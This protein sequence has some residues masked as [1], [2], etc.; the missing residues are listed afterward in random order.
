[1]N[2]C[3]SGQESITHESVH[4]HDSSFSYKICNDLYFLSIPDDVDIRQHLI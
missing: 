2:D 1:M 3:M 4:M